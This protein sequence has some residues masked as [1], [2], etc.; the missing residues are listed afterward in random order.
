MDRY[1]RRRWADRGTRSVITGGGLLIVASILAMLVFLVYETLPLAR[2]ARIEPEPP[3]AAARPDSPVRVL[4]ANEYLDI[5]F[6]VDADG[7]SRIVDALSQTIRKER[8]L[9][10][11]GIS[12]KIVTAVSLSTEAERW[13][14]ATDHGRVFP[15]T[16][17]DGRYFEGSTRQYRPTI[18][19]GT[20]ATIDSTQSVQMIAGSLRS[21]GM[22]AAVL[23]ADGS[24]RLLE[25]TQKKSLVGAGK[26]DDRIREIGLPDQVQPTALALDGA[27][28]SLF[29]G[30]SAGTIVEWTLENGGEVS[31]GSYQASTT[32]ISHLGMLLGGH[33]LVV[34]SESGA[35]QVWFH[36][37][38]DDAEHRLIHAHSFDSQAGKIEGS[39]ASSRGRMFATYDSRGEARI[40]F[41]TTSQTRARFSLGSE[42]I[43][44][45]VMSPKADALLSV[46]ASGTVRSFLIDDP[47][48]EASMRSL[49]T[50][51]HYEG[52]PEAELSWQS[53][54][55]TD[56]SEPKLSLVP[57][58]FGSL[59]GTLYAMLFST[60]IA[61]F[62][63]L[64]TAA[65]MRPRLRAIVKP[66]MELMATI[67]SV[68]LG[69][70]AGIWL[71]PRLERGMPIVLLAG[72]FLVVT[73]V[74]AGWLRSRLPESSRRRVPA[75]T[76][77]IALLPVLVIG[78]VLM[79]SLN[80]GLDAAFPGGFLDWMYQELTIRYDQRN[81]LVVG[82]AMGLAVIPI[83]FSISED[84]LSSVPKHLTAGSL[85]LGATPWQT[86]WQVLLP[87]ASPG[88]FSALM[89]GFG[90]AVGETMIMLMATGNTPIMDWSL[91][92]GFRTLSANIATEIGEAP[93]GGSLYRLLFL[94]ALLLFAF[95]LIVNTTAE[96]VR[97]RLRQ[98]Y[99]RF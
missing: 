46:D 95:T 10:G 54:G 4:G 40:H 78:L 64:Y 45:I 99:S 9:F 28:R 94:S 13:L 71:A 22:T 23:L 80:G 89:I 30:T 85:A 48:P 70:L 8:N 73:I 61:V 42:A 97:S 90:R 31:A 2:R 36:A 65:F 32:P 33:S 57:L 1:T 49:F 91:F 50:P 34:G 25:R 53:T 63:A 6:T 74:L 77:V 26:I 7:Q 17:D 16:F 5:I 92:N 18:T 15:V 68:V 75:G 41:A 67:P 11:E 12:E 24:L 98:R 93:Q 87:A 21:D 76:E 56:E 86:A 27:G 14:I 59:K 96:I 3:L 66:V 60:P 88:I 84:A 62:A 82:I 58:M 72:P 52:F 55:G 44:T 83:I 39:A 20:P 29:V 51:I 79:L 38:I 81:A 69:L 43:Q 19:L 35:L 37:R 47:H